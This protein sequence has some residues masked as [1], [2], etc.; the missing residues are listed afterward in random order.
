MLKKHAKIDT[1]NEREEVGKINTL[2]SAYFLI[3]SKLRPP[4]LRPFFDERSE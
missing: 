4:H 3:N 2:T 1:Y